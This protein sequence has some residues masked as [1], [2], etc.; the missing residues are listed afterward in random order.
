M[1]RE[2]TSSGSVVARSGKWAVLSF[3]ARLDRFE[4]R[5]RVIESGAVMGCHHA[6][7]QQGAAWRDGGVE[8]GVD[9]YTCVVERAPEKHC[10]PVIAY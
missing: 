6:R 4:R 9:E 3:E 2:I 8:R 1:V 7:S 10:L 5:Q